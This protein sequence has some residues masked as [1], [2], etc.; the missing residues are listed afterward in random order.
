MRILSI[1]T[2]FLLS[3]SIFVQ[4][5]EL[6]PLVAWQTIVE[7]DNK[8]Y[9]SYVWATSGTD[10]LKPKNN[11][12][13]YFGD[14][15]GQI[16]ITYQ[17]Y[18]N[19]MTSVRLVVEAP[20][21]MRKSEI[22]CFV[23]QN[24]TP[25]EIFPEIDYRFDVLNGNFQPKP[26]MIKYTLYVNDK[27]AY[28]KTQNIVL[29]SIYECPYAFVHRSGTLL[30]QNFM[31]SAYVNENH[32]VI[33]EQLLPEILDTKVVDKITGYLTYSSGEAEG[34]VEVMR[35]IFGLWDILRKRN[36]QYSSITG[37]NTS[38]TVIDQY[39]RTVEQ[40]LKSSQANC[41]D[42]TVL[43]ASVLYRMGIEPSIVL[44]PGHAYLGFYLDPA[45]GSNTRTQFF[46]ETTL[47]GA[48]VP[49]SKLS[50]TFTDVGNAIANDEI[51]TNHRSSFIAFLYAL[52]V[53]TADYKKNQ[54]KFNLQDIN[55]RIFEV[56]AHRKAGILPLN[57]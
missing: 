49:E 38:N 10:Y 16:G 41:I 35:Q 21:I 19:K 3:T 25:V 31:F 47:L 2:T 43:M 54:S 22:S 24:K 12:P 5:Q 46:L 15:E 42:G 28:S 6:K 29:T 37:A 23:P 30:D 48:N 57:H 36:I 4:A 9:P 34:G 53:A 1:I 32:P 18:S 52:D 45:N 50:K 51:L 26:V 55:Y 13:N 11:N 20:G 14:S 44:V 39:V 56:D 8:I 40:S 27:Y 7:M 33:A 17:N